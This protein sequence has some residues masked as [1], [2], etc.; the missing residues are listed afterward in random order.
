MCKI[1]SEIP[2]RNLLKRDGFVYSGHLTSS[3]ITYHLRAIDSFYCNNWTTNLTMSFFS[4]PKEIR[5]SIQSVCSRVFV[6]RLFLTNCWLKL[7][8]YVSFVL[9]LTAYS[10]ATDKW[11]L[12]IC[13][14]HSGKY[15][16]KLLIFSCFVKKQVFDMNNS[17]A[18]G[19]YCVINLPV[20]FQISV[21][22]CHVI[23]EH[24]L[25]ILYLHHQ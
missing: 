24:V 3:N 9:K 11:P 8:R 21:V 23:L 7:K 14:N 13:Q 25:Y 10:V 2:S 17:V 16:S 18:I 19:L 4:A 15:T 6:Y 5:G 22:L 1:I 12:D 20:T